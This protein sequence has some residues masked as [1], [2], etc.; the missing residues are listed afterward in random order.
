MRLAVTAETTVSESP[1]TTVSD[2]HETTIHLS[3]STL[4]SELP[5][6]SR[7]ALT[8]PSLDCSIDDAL[9]HSTTSDTVSP[10]VLL[11]HDSITASSQR[12]ISYACDDSAATMERISV[13]LA[14]SVTHSSTASSQCLIS[15]G[16]DDSAAS[17]ATMECNSVDFA[18]SVTDR[19]WTDPDSWIASHLDTA[20]AV[21]ATLVDDATSCATKKAKHQPLRFPN[22]DIHSHVV[23]DTSADVVPCIDGPTKTFAPVDDISHVDHE[24]MPPLAPDEVSVPPVFV[25]NAANPLRIP[26]LAVPTTTLVLLAP[27]VPPALL[28]PQPFDEL[29]PPRV[30]PPR[31][32]LLPPG[33]PPPPLCGAQLRSNTSTVSTTNVVPLHPPIFDSMPPRKPRMKVSPPKKSREQSTLRSPG[34]HRRQSRQRPAQCLSPTI[35]DTT[36]PDIAHDCTT[37]DQQTLADDDPTPIISVLDFASPLVSTPRFAPPQ[38][39]ASNHLTI[40]S[41]CNTDVHDADPNQTNDESTTTPA[42][43]ELPVVSLCTI[44]PLAPMLDSFDSTGTPDAA[45]SFLMSLYAAPLCDEST[46]TFVSAPIPLVDNILPANTTSVSFSALSLLTSRD[47]LSSPTCDHAIPATSPMLATTAATAQHHSDDLAISGTRCMTLSDEK[48]D[49]SLD[50][51]PAT[52]AEAVGVV[53]NTTVKGTTAPTLWLTHSVWKCSS[54]NSCNAQPSRCTN[55]VLATSAELAADVALGIDGYTETLVDVTPH[56]PQ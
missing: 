53:N 8:S 3:A 5:V 46:G 30:F 34:N 9:A 38:V 29:S 27:Q 45:V 41:V 31:D 35:V 11:A 24:R 23:L 49:S 19:P 54:P 43:A 44:S 37:I 4:T 6:T 56:W 18:T 51:I 26:V 50:T 1:T 33:E 55:D 36:A 20:V 32:E 10:P 7:N 2:E 21:S 13:D 14:T 42:I 16:C 17:S 39:T 12:L 52:S 28:L 15:Y 47:A 48:V 25:E 22:V 40:G